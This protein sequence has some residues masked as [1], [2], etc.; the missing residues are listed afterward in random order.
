MSQVNIFV[1]DQK[2]RVKYEQANKIRKIEWEDKHDMSQKFL[3]FLDKINICNRNSSNCL[4]GSP[5][6]FGGNKPD[7]IKPHTDSSGAR[8]FEPTIVVLNQ[9]GRETTTY[10]IALISLRAL[11]W[12]GVL[13]LSIQKKK[14]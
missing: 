14:K 6:D 7:S 10:R 2:V 13:S 3:V 4:F 9:G 12:T 11:A 8:V 5:T 1:R